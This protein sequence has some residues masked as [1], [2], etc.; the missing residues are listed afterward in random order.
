MLI[1]SFTLFLI[2]SAVCAGRVQ[3]QATDV[4]FD[5][6][7]DVDLSAMTLSPTGLY[8]KVLTE[9]DGEAATVGVRIAIA[10]TAYLPDGTKF[11]E[12]A[13]D[14]PFEVDLGEDVMIPGFFEGLL[15]IRIGESRLLVIP[16]DLAY[17]VRGVDGV[18]QPGATLVFRVER[19]ALPRS[20][21]PDRKS[22]VATAGCGISMS[23]GCSR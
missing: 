4:Q 11:S 6:S 7:L 1:R 14:E 13:P 18:I 16:P 8:S 15:G 21:A 17:G 10:F 22:W 9:G 20:A 23:Y 19:V 3:C 2:A 5:P 12:S